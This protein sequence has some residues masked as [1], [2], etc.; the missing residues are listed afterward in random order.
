MIKAEPDSL[1]LIYSEKLT[2]KVPVIPQINIQLRK[3]YFQS[4]KTVV[5]P[6]SIEVSGDA[7][8]LK[9]ISFIKTKPVTFS[10]VNKKMIF[11]TELDM[12]AK[13]SLTYSH[14]SVY[15]LIPVEEYAEGKI[16]VPVEEFNFGKRMVKIFPTKIVVNYRSSLAKFESMNENDFKIVIDDA[17]NAVS[18]G[19]K[20]LKVK[21][22]EA[23]FAANIVSMEP[24][25]V[26]YFLIEK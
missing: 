11:S 26:D 12:L 5:F 4:G 25:Y 10:N 19:N 20:K 22:S 3:Q 15:I 13:Y 17:A 6:D 7:E 14:H 16:A 24:E 21:L 1:E 9:N 2:I 18:S 23:P 8:D